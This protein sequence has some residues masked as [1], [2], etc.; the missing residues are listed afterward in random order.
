MRLRRVKLD[1]QR[2]QRVFPGVQE[3]ELIYFWLNC[4]ELI[5]YGCMSR[6]H[7]YQIDQYRLHQYFDKDEIYLN[8]D[9]FSRQRCICT[10]ESIHLNILRREYFQRIR[11]CLE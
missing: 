2:L 11:L 8:I 4:K 1:V 10:A 9:K 5:H 6:V 3:E 7:H